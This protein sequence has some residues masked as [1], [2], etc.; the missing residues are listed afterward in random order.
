MSGEKKGRCWST[1]NKYMVTTYAA[2]FKE[3]KRQKFEVSG[4]KAAG[5][6]RTLVESKL[7]RSNGEPVNL[8]YLFRQSKDAW[9]VIDIYLAGSISQMAQMRSDFAKTSSSTAGRMS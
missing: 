6:G 9:R 2:R 1:F 7:I 8:N 5:E 3:Y 4:A